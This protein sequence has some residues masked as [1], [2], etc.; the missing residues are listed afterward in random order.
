[1]VC[2]IQT[3]SL[4]LTGLTPT[5]AGLTLGLLT[6]ANAR[7]IPLLKDLALCTLVPL[8]QSMLL[9]FYTFVYAGWNFKLHST[10][11][12]PTKHEASFFI[13][14]MLYFIHS[15]PFGSF[16][17]QTISL[18]S[19]LSRN[20]TDNFLHHSIL[21]LTSKWPVPLK[22]AYVYCEFFSVFSFF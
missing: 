4:G 19:S 15:F 9:C 10:K 3:Q 18:Y 20:R 14:A 17:I 22:H 12:K 11:G 21:F 7:A 5:L 8:L 16:A 13:S 6:F 1:M 2:L